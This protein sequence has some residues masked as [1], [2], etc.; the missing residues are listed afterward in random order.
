MGRLFWKFFLA[1]WLAP[2]LPA[3][4]AWLVLRPPI[5]R[6]AASDTAVVLGVSY[7][8]YVALSPAVAAQL[9]GMQGLGGTVGML[10]TGSGVGALA[11]PP[12][13]GWL[14]DTTGSYRVA[15]IAALV[16]AFGSFLLLLAALRRPAS[17]GEPAP[18]T[19]TAQPS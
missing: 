18:A 3:L 4:G 6:R 10:Y 15:E 12:A 19:A 9:F 2:A 7:G 1:F 8:G 13:A 5:E 14:I 11:G 17:V 16:I